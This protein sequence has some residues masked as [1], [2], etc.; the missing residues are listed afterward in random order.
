MNLKIIHWCGDIYR[1]K[2]FVYF[3]V[4]GMKASK[5]GKNVV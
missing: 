4:C 3:I 2:I 1:E 5:D